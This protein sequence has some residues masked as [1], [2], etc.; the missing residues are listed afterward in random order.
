MSPQLDLTA[1]HGRLRK[2]VREFLRAIEYVPFRAIDCDQDRVDR[3]MEKLER[4][5]GYRVP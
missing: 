3:L 1:A 5:S 4:L 2:T